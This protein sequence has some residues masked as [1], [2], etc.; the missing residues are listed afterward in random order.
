MIQPG[1]RNLWLLSSH[2]VIYI[3]WH[4][5]SS[6]CSSPLYCTLGTKSPHQQPWTSRCIDLFL[7]LLPWFYL[8]E[9]L[10]SEYYAMVLLFDHVV[11]M[12]NLTQSIYITF[13]LIG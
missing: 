3:I 8:C 6:Y 5:S 11:V 12:V 9:G 4:L 1:R 10:A 13:D 7:A 2:L